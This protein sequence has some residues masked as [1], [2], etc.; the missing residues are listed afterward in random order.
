MDFNF[1]C[2]KVICDCL[3][4]EIDHRKTVE[5]I[6]EPE[7]IVDKRDLINAKKVIA[8]PEYR[9]GFMEKEGFLPNLSMLDLMFNEGP[10]SINYLKQLETTI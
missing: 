6:R 5:Y 1:D 10:N 9:Q 3:Q 2:F 7:D 4:L 8:I